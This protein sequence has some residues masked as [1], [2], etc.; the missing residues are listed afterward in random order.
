MN[1][2][3][4]VTRLSMQ[5]PVSYSSALRLLNPFLTIKD[6]CPFK[7]NISLS[8]ISGKGPPG[9]ARSPGQ[10]GGLFTNHY[11]TQISLQQ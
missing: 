11:L 8:P 9:P 6:Q 4:P 2:K 7:Q 3:C 5:S 1:Q 10:R